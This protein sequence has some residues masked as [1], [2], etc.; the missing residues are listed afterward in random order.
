MKKVVKVVFVGMLALLFLTAC[1]SSEEKEEKNYASTNSSIKEVDTNQTAEFATIAEKHIKEIYGINDLKMDLQ[2]IKVTQ[3]P[4]DK[5]AET[6]EEYKNVFNGTGDFTWNNQ[7]YNFSLIYSKK[8]ATNYTV[9]YLY[10]NLDTNKGID[11]PLES[12]Q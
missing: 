7:E 1:G 10:S 6:G 9:L 12:D 2:S 5:N 8:D 11:T 3:F 4:D